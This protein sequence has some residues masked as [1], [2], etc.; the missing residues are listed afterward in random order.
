[1]DRCFTGWLNSLPVCFGVP[2]FGTVLTTLGAVIG[3]GASAIAIFGIVA[4]ALD[5]G[6]SGWFIIARWRNQSIGD[7]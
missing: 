6:G 7:S 4:F 2:I 5:T 3:F 1:M